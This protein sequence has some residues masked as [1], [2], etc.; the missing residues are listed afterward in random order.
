MT[1]FKPHFSLELSPTPK[2]TAEPAAPSPFRAVEIRCRSEACAAAKELC[3]TRYLAV[4]AP[5]LPLPECDRIAE[6]ACH[7]RH[8]A[9]RRVELRRQASLFEDAHHDYLSEADDA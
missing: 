8:L 2:N 6:C 3:G 5:L 7:Y 9:D 1:F 4:E